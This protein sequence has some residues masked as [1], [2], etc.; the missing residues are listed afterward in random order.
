MRS[1]LD[2]KAR[3]VQNGGNKYIQ[4]APSALGATVDSLE[5]TSVSLIVSDLKL[6]GADPAANEQVGVVRSGEFLMIFDS[7]GANYV[8]DAKVLTGIYPQV[9]FEVHP[10]HGDI[11]SLIL[12]DI[13]Y[14]D[15]VTYGTSNTVIIHGYAFRQNVKIP[16]VFVSGLTMNGQFFFSSP[17][18][19]EAGMREELRMRFFS[20]AAFESDGAVMDPTDI[21]N[22]TEIE[23][24]LRSS[25][26]V[27]RL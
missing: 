8:A 5:V 18:M 10:L 15:F 14:R 1:D 13:R 26:G 27:F 16:F 7:S 6:H 24:N 4:H 21:R 23:N 25:V 12:L 17:L 19:I 11:D 2:A 3:P 22:R 20:Q 9:K